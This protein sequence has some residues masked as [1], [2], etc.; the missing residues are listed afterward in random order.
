MTKDEERIVARMAELRDLLTVFGAKLAGYDPGVSAWIPHKENKWQHIQFDSF[1][2][3]WLE[4]LLIE[5]R[6]YRSLDMSRKEA[7][8]VLA[9]DFV[10]F[11]QKEEDKEDAFNAWHNK[12]EM[13][14]AKQ[15]TYELENMNSVDKRNPED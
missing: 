11:V 10:K 12:L 2:W 8:R 7:I 5:L 13:D 6:N 15:I 3:S 4:P 1:E 9:K 14:M